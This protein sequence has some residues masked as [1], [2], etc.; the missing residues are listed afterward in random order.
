MFT[1][2][3]PADTQHGVCALWGLAGARDR[4]R[5]RARAVTSQSVRSHNFEIQTL[6]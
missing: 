3:Y 5:A 2:L 4:D 1:N 6:F